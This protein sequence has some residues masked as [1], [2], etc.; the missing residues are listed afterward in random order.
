MRK[1]LFMLGASFLMTFGVSAQSISI[2]NVDELVLADPS[3]SLLQAHATLTNN[4]S[5]PID[6]LV[7]F[8]EISAGPV[9]SGHYFC[10]AVCY[11]EG[12]VA[13]GFQTPANHSVTIDAGATNSSSFYS[14]YVPHGTIGMAS[15]EYCFSDENNPSDE[16]CIQI[17]F[18]TRNVGI[19]DVFATNNSGISEAYPNPANSNVKMNYSLEPSWNNATLDV[20]SMLGSRVRTL[21]INEKSGTVNLDVSSLPAGLYFYTLMVDGNAINTKKMLVT[22]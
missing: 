5:A 8:N 2:T 3:E 12:G 13:D 18:D 17:I 15:Y 21:S 16:T 6:V 14:D 1:N 10:W 4:S 19:E 7:R 11:T 9:G 22:K 20:Y